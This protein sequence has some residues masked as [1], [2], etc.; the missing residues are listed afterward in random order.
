MVNMK[1][2]A[3]A[4][5]PNTDGIHIQQSSEVTVM[6]THIGTG[7]DFISAG[8]DHQNCPT[9]PPPNPNIARLV[10]QRFCRCHPGVTIAASGRGSGGGDGHR[11]WT[12]GRDNGGGVGVK[13]SDVAYEDIRTS[14]TQVVVKLDCS[15]KNPCSGITLDGDNLSYRDNRATTSCANAAGSA[16][17]AA[18]FDK[19]LV[20]Y[21]NINV[22]CFN[23]IVNFTVM[24]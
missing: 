3:P 6:N 12:A 24:S 2:S 23:V 22:H 4:N 1:I 10:E 14:A 21:I 19:F 7:D 17:S 15:K 13:I 11:W 20:N 9:Q 5:S 8:P 16:G 18:D